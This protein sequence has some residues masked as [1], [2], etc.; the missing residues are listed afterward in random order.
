M[1][2]QHKKKPSFYKDIIRKHWADVCEKYPLPTEKNYCEILLKYR[3]QGI[4]SGQYT[5]KDIQSQM[6]R[7]LNA[8]ASGS[9]PFLVHE[10]RVFLPVKIKNRENIW[11]K[12]NTY[13]FA[14]P[15]FF[16]ISET[17]IAI[18]FSECVSWELKTLFKTFFDKDCYDVVS[19]DTVVLIF[20][21]NDNNVFER[22]ILK[23]QLET[24]ISDGYYQ[25]NPS[26]QKPTTKPTLQIQSQPELSNCPTSTELPSLP[27]H[28]FFT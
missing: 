17:T 11:K 6:S 16:T 13:K 3:N 14:Q 10:G 4:T 9:N 19:V 12:I 15:N 25:Q 1:A 7:A 28:P 2:K 22:A 20:L 18:S 8:L 23:R 5:I 21:K 26:I 24:L 27:Y